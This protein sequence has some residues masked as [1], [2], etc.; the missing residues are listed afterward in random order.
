MRAAIA[1][2]LLITASSPALADGC[3]AAAHRVFPVLVEEAKGT[4]HEA[5]IAASIAENGEGATIAG[6]AATLTDEQC[7]FLLTA[8]DSTIRAI[9]IS[10]L[11]ERNGE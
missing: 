9:A 2:L 6:I 4:R 7:G 8:D 11:P 10:M 1:A 3:R 5:Q